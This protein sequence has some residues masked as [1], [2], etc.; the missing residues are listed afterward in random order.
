SIGG[1]K[2][3]YYSAADELTKWIKL[4]EEGHISEE[5]FNQAR[6]KLL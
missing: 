1:D 6:K 4:K 5:E 3:K 2:L